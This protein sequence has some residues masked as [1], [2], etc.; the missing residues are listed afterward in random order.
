MVV[1][2][3]SLYEYGGF[4]LLFPPL[5]LHITFLVTVATS[6]T[7]RRWWEIFCNRDTELRIVT[8]RQSACLQAMPRRTE[9][10]TLNIQI[11]QWYHDN[12]Q[13]GQRCDVKRR[14][15]FIGVI[16]WILRTVGLPTMAVIPT[17]F[18]LSEKY[19]FRE[20]QKNNNWRQFYFANR[21]I[22]NIDGSKKADFA[23]L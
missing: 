5:S 17:W 7:F 6:Q 11:P 22:K 18:F 3:C 1:P 13:E 8:I 19:G 16:P 12:N 4:F 9:S 21:S 2:W 20:S 10:G 14:N 15:C 23:V